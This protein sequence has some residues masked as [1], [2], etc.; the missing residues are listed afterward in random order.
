MKPIEVDDVVIVMNPSVPSERWSKGRVVK[1]Y[2]G[3][4]D[5]VR[6]VD[7]K[8]PNGKIKKRAAHYVAVLDVR[9]E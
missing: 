6:V 4:D 9:K 5:Q 3:K 1:T 7:V 2:I 8:M